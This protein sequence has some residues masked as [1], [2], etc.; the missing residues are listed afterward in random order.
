MRPPVALVIALG[1]GM[2][3][4]MRNHLAFLAVIYVIPCPCRGWLFRLQ[5]W[6]LPWAGRHEYDSTAEL[7]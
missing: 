3:M 4:R 5:L 2:I 1:A 7:E 6:L